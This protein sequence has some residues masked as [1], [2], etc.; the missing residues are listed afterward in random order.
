MH[1]GTFARA[2]ALNKVLSGDLHFTQIVGDQ[3]TVALR[4]DGVILTF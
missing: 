2:D 3:H 4:S 1:L